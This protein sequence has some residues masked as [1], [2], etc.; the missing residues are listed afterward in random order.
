[1]NTNIIIN[2]SK[3]KLNL[4]LIPLFLLAVIVLF[5]YSQNALSVDKCIEIQKNLFFF[6]NYNLGQFPNIQYNLTQLGDAL[7]LLSFLSIFILYASK[8]WEALLSALLVSFLFSYSLKKN[9]C[10]SK[11]CS[12]F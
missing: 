11:T 8:I 2:Y 10:S 9:I 5:L 1:M 4:F 3:L 12:S 7:I 6:I